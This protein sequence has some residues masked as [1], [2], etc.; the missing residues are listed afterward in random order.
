MIYLN[1]N[2]KNM[3]N[4]KDNIA[5]NLPYIPLMGVVAAIAVSI[6]NYV[7]FKKGFSIENILVPLAYFLAFLL[8]SLIVKF[9]LS[10]PSF[11]FSKGQV[12]A[13]II[14]WIVFLIIQI[15]AFIKTPNINTLSVEQ[16][17]NYSDDIDNE[18]IFIYASEDCPFCKMQKKEL[19]N[20]SNERENL[21]YVDMNKLDSA[22]NGY[23]IVKNMNV[24]SVPVIVKYK[25]NK[26]IKRLTG[27][28][29]KEELENFIGGKND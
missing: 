28:T 23:K 5:K 24:T 1:W 29:K 3:I 4:H 7:L 6:G 11:N 20:I 15:I 9:I 26:E 27:F 12:S 19:H 2:T 13:F 14:L 16:A 8:F 22:F 21:F 10:I 18:Y 25:G 17:L